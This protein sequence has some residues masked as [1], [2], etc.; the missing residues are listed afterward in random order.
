MIESK[1]IWNV[2]TKLKP[3][4]ILKCACLPTFWPQISTVGWA[5]S[6]TW[7][8][9]LFDLRPILHH[10]ACE[11]SSASLSPIHLEMK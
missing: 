5:L 10:P 9:R 7:P 11:S 3:S 8:A 6:S 4:I 2:E 1:H